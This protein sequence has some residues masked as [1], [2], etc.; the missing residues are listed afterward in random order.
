V[1]EGHGPY[2][3]F[4]KGGGEGRGRFGPVEKD[5]EELGGVAA[6]RGDNPATALPQG[7]PL[8]MMELMREREARLSERAV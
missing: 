6:A 3:R 8:I 7:A 2:N 1:G 4:R 5:E